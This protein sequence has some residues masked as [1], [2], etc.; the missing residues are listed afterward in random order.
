M[1]SGDS[2]VSWESLSSVACPANSVVVVDLDVDDTDVFCVV[3]VV[4]GVVVVAS[5]VSFFSSSCAS[6]STLG[7]FV[8]FTFFLLLSPLVL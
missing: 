2:V 6:V 8:V 5:S 1:F 3:L 4:A 7:A